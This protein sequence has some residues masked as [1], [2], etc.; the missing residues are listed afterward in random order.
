MEP[1]RSIYTDQL[2]MFYD[3]TTVWV[4]IP[5]GPLDIYT[6]D[7]SLYGSDSY[8]S[9]L[10]TYV[11]GLGKDGYGVDCYSIHVAIAYDNSTT[12]YG[13][14]NVNI[15]ST[16]CLSDS[17]GVLSFGYCFDTSHR[18]HVLLNNETGYVAMFSTYGQSG[19]ISATYYQLVIPSGGVIKQ[20]ANGYYLTTNG[21]GALFLYSVQNGGTLVS[22]LTTDTY[23]PDASLAFFG[24]V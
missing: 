16:K 18:C 9:T 2:C 15:D 1:V 3:G 23:D 22:E 24:L 12:L 8:S 13:F 19:T 20:F 17:S 7:P 21:A 6:G 11:T 14:C 10:T 4:N 5:S